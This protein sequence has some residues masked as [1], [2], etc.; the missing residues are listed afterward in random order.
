[1]FCGQS[2]SYSNLKM[3]NFQEF[4]RVTVAEKT[5]PTAKAVP[6]LR[7]AQY[8]VSRGESRKVF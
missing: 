8:D 7:Q 6:L 1:M 4:M 2:F 3:A 5:H